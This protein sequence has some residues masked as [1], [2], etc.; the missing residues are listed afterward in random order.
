MVGAP[1][2]NPG[3]RKDVRVQVPP[4]VRKPPSRRCS[5]LRR[6]SRRFDSC[7]RHAAP[8]RSAVR[9]LGFHPGN[10]GS[11]PVR[12]PI[13]PYIPVSFNGRTT[14]SDPVNRGSNPCAGAV[15]EAEVVEAPGC[16]PGLSGFKSRRLPHS[17]VVQR[18]D[19]V[20]WCRV[21]RFES[22]RGIYSLVS[23]LRWARGTCAV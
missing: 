4:S 17:L 20:F 11:T 23:F 15:A 7:R 6:L 19:H 14:G 22:C 9:T 18:Q 13:T 8:V 1:G 10:A 16:D 12:A 5:T 2:P 3:V 21:C